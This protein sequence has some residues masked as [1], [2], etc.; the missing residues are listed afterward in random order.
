LSRQEI[1]PVL[2]GS[3]PATNSETWV[4]WEDAISA[5]MIDVP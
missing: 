5:A 3:T 1:D 4:I 2:A